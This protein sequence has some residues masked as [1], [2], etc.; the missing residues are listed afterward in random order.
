MAVAT[1][2][3]RSRAAPAAP[4]A[5]TTE[6]WLRC[7]HTR[8]C[9][10]TGS[11]SELPP[12]FHS[13]QPPVLPEPLL[14][15]LQGRSCPCPCPAEPRQCPGAGDLFLLPCPLPQRSPAAPALAQSPGVLH[16]TQGNVQQHHVILHGFIQGFGSFPTIP[17]NTGLAQGGHSCCCC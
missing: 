10:R 17:C 14:P 8:C 2:S 6:E 7:A 13:P 12:A 3:A 15:A 9:G 11:Y 1:T 5:P 4:T 16:G